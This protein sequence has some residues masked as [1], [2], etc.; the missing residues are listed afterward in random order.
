[1]PAALTEPA[2]RCY[3]A[4]P[5]AGMPDY[6]HEAFAVAAFGLRRLGLEVVSPAELHADTDKTRAHYMSIDVHALLTTH[7]VAALPGWESSQGA[8]L[9]VDLAEQTGRPVMCITGRTMDA[10]REAIRR[11]PPGA[12]GS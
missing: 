9:E 5:M 3:I 1:M 12:G 8:L 4:G 10:W 6:N 11:S 2:I 7:M